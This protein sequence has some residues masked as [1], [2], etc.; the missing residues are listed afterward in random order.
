MAQDDGKWFLSRDRRCMPGEERDGRDYTLWSKHRPSEDAAGFYRGVGFFA[1]LTEAD[2][3]A[4][5]D[6]PLLKPGEYIEVKLVRTE[7]GS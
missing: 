4:A 3:R 2:V 1:S 6:G 5:L 7:G